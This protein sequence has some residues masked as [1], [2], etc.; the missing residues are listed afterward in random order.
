MSSA[1][2]EGLQAALR[3]EHGA[4]WG[5]GVVGAAVPPDLRVYVRDLDAAHRATRDT[6]ADLIRLRAAEPE[7]AQASY[8]LPYP[9]VDAGTGFTFAAALEIAITQGYAF[10]VSRAATQRAKAFSLAALTEAALRQTFWTKLSG[11]TPV[12]PEFPG[13]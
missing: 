7:P 3:A 10:A 4:I 8:E 2:L 13:L 1:E 6:L 12:T 11:A 9:V 5:Y